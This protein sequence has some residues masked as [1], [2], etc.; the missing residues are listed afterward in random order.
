MCQFRSEKNIYI[1]GLLFTARVVLPTLERG[2]V[3]IS[4]FCGDYCFVYID[5][6]NIKSDC[7]YQDG[8]HLLDTG[9]YGSLLAPFVSQKNMTFVSRIETSMSNYY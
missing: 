7:L 2:H 6:K 5:N 8:L 3:L 1:S 9:K 4:N